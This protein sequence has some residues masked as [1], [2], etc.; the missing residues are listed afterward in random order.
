MQG[1]HS[2]KRKGAR[3]LGSK[4]LIDRAQ[5]LPRQGNAPVIRIQEG[6][7]GETWLTEPPEHL[8][9]NGD[10][11]QTGGRFGRTWAQAHLYNC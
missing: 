10:S 2:T 1:P 9:R 11:I 5:I 4:T 3:K 8:K 7:G 6:D